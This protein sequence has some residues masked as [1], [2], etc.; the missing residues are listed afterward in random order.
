[1]GILRE[2]RA[3][4]AFQDSGQTL[5]Q[6]SVVCTPELPSNNTIMGQSLQKKFCSH[7]TSLQTS[8]PY[9]EDGGD[10]LQKPACLS[11]GY[12]RDFSKAHVCL[13]LSPM[14]CKSL[15]DLPCLVQ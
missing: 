4:S 10:C 2:Q 6:G 5:G 8:L 3:A 15:A 13:K 12:W 7:V 14:A 9:P 11:Q 1:M